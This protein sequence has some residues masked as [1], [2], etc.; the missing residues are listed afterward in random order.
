MQ[1]TDPAALARSFGFTLP[2]PAYLFFAIVFGVVGIAA[3]RLGRKREQH[4]TSGLGVALM[5]YPYVVGS[6]TWLVVIGAALC[7]GVWWDLRR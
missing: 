1:D 3:F 6:T 5:V 7:A 2:S 4:L